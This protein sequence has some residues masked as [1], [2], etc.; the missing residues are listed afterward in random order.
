MQGDALLAARLR[1]RFAGRRAAF[2]SVR[3]PEHAN[4]GQHDRGLLGANR[5]LEQVGQQIER[6]RGQGRVQLGTSSGQV[7]AAAGAHRVML[8]R[9][10]QEHSLRR[11]VIWLQVE[12]PPGV[13]ETVVFGR[14]GRVIVASLRALPSQI[15]T[16][17]AGSPSASPAIFGRLAVP[18]WN[19][20]A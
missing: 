17:C 1:T 18:S 4:D 7:Y 20:W 11:G 9:N 8:D 15:Q 5:L 12:G 19:F 14:L 3:S 13:L 2:A 16:L 10:A 6:G